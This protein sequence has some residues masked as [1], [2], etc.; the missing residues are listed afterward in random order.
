MLFTKFFLAMYVFCSGHMT[1]D[2]MHAI[3]I[4]SGLYLEP[5]DSYYQHFISLNLRIKCRA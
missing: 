1:C 5:W 3:K 2:Q 4:L